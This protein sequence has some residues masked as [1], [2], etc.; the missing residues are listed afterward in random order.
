M[1]G[2]SDFILNSTWHPQNNPNSLQ[3]CV[4]AQEDLSCLEHV[5]ST[6]LFVNTENKFLKNAVLTVS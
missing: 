5:S 4:F 2:L 1:K 6:L 3:V